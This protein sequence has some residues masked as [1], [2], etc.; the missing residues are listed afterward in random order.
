MACENCDRL[1]R[2]LQ[3]REKEVEALWESLKA[4][5]MKSSVPE[6]LKVASSAAQIAKLSA[7]GF[8]EGDSVADEAAAV[9]LGALKQVRERLEE[10]PDG[11]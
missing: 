2:L 1:K 6:L 10:G 9:A 7:Q 5:M 4:E 11:R 8:P 3:A